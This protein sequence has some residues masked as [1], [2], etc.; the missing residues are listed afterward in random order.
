MTTNNVTRLLES[1]NVLFN[2]V[3]LPPEKLGAVDTAEFLKVSPDLVYKTIVLLRE[4]KGK[5]IL[6]VIA[7]DQRVDLKKVAAAL[8]EKKVTTATEKGA[9]QLT[10]LKVGGISALAL[11][12][13]GFEVL[14]DDSALNLGEFY[15]SGGMRG[16]LIWMRVSDYV[17]I[18]S[19][20]IAPIT[21]DIV[22]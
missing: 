16:L 5:P 17:A 8:D 13:R 4:K 3:E 20:R 19:A 11:L 12:N 21:Q 15:V 1:K 9:E 18:T 2:A 7:G 6:A 14:L 10:G 22:P